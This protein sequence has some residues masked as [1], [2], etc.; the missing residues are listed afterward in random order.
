MIKII[1]LIKILLRNIIRYKR[2]YYIMVAIGFAA[3]FIMV[4][5]GFTAGVK[6]QLFRLMYANYTGDLMI[7]NDQVKIKSDPAPLQVGWDQMLV[8]NG[9]LDQMRNID[10]IDQIL[11]RMVLMASSMGEDEEKN[12]YTSV[13]GC[14]FDKEENYSFKSL[15]SFVKRDQKIKNGVYVSQKIADKLNLKVG[16]HIYL[17][18]ITENG[19]VP[20]KFNVAAIFTGKGFPGIVQNLIYIDYPTL[21]DSLMLAEQKISFGLVMLKDQNKTNETINQIKKIAPGDA[22]IVTPKISGQFFVAQGVMYDLILGVSMALMYLSIFLFVYST[23][24]ISIKSRQREIGIMSSLGI[25]KKDIFTI[26]TG[27]GMLLGFI[28]A[29]FGCLLGLIFVNIFS[30]I[31][32]PALNDSMRYAFAS[33]VLYLQV[34]LKAILFSIIGISLIAFLGAISPTLKILKLNP[35]DA[36]KDS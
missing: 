36:L 19:M 15:L 5:A 6:Q 34:D 7:I 11:R 27:E 1:N 28:P 21:I 18:F 8:D 22:S 12:V 4:I 32:I 13:I 3:F 24:I 17:F 29:I 35:V 14:E 31:G 25:S 10:N 20:A 16:D 2:N 23:L 30:V 33:D 26:C 9:F